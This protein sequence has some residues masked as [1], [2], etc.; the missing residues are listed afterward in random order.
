MGGY[1]GNRSTNWSGIFPGYGRIWL[2]RGGPANILALT[3]R[4]VREETR[5]SYNA[6]NGFVVSTPGGI[7]RYRRGNFGR[8]YLD[9]NDFDYHDIQHDRV[10]HHNAHRMLEENI[11]GHFLPPRRYGPFQDG[12]DGRTMEGFRYF[13]AVWAL[14]VQRRFATQFMRTIHGDDWTRAPRIEEGNRTQLGRDQELLRAVLSRQAAVLRRPF[15]RQLRYGAPRF[16]V[17]R[18]GEERPR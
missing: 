8:Q 5:V 12:Q 18:R 10:D 13:G 4:S 15:N 3:D 16:D 9:E 14:R 17:N 6:H 7:W 11:P 1:G 2:D